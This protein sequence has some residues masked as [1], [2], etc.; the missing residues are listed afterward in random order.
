[1][2]NNTNIDND[3]VN[4]FAINLIFKSSVDFDT[5]SS[6]EISKKI[7]MFDKNRVEVVEFELLCGND[8]IEK[9]IKPKLITELSLQ[10][11]NE[12]LKE[13]IYY[14]NQDIKEA[15]DGARRR[16]LETEEPAGL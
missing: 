9:V 12:M 1:M 14:D 5:V 15:E 4:L 11:C 16:N 6:I 13:A 10:V 8:V 3:L 7:D 2:L